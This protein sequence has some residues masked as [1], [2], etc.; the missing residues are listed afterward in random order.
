LVA[1]GYGCGYA[2]AG[3]L[4]VR[5]AFGVGLL[6]LVQGVQQGCFGFGVGLLLRV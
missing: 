2:G 1:G 4:L 5:P 3:D 6:V